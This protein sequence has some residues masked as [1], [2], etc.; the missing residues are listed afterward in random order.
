LALVDPFE[1]EDDNYRP[2]PAL[3][4]HPTLPLCLQQVGFLDYMDTD[5]DT[6]KY[7]TTR[8]VIHDTV[9]LIVG[10][11]RKSSY[12][13]AGQLEYTLETCHKRAG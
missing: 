3:P 10:I 13:T 9:S 7:A 2:I 5:F 1:D 6:L 12:P 11:S 4:R 8:Y